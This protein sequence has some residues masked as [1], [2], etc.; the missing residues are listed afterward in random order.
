MVMGTDTRQ[1]GVQNRGR[2]VDV[3]SVSDSERRQEGGGF[4]LVD[5]LD[6]ER[7]VERGVLNHKF[8]PRSRE[9]WLVFGVHGPA[10][11]LAT[12]AAAAPAGFTFAGE[13][14]PLLRE[15][16]L[17]GLPVA[18]LVMVTAALLAALLTDRLLEHLPRVGRGFAAVVF[19]V[20]LAV[21][22]TNLFI[23]L[24]PVIRV[25]SLS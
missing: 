8:A 6:R 14:N 19:G 13:G 20:G 7:L 11:V 17:A 24:T 21:V 16:L 3:R 10:D 15:L 9:A 22:V 12:I 25:L 2:N 1:G 18:A 23:A 4:G 5:A